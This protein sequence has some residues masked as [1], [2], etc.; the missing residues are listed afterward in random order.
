[1]PQQKLT[2]DATS[3][4]A[5]NITL[6][7]PQPQAGGVWTGTIGVPASPSAVLWGVTINNTHVATIVGASTYGPI[8]FSQG[9]IVKMTAAGVTP[10]TQYQM[11]LIGTLSP[12]GSA[13]Q[14]PAAYSN[15]IAVVTLGPTSKVKITGTVDVLVQNASIPVTGNVNA[16]IT[17]A[18]I[19]VTGN[20]NATITNAS[21]PVTG[22]VNA[23]ITNASIPVTGT[24]AI[25]SGSITATLSG[26]VS[27]NGTKIAV[28]NQPG[29]FLV[30]G[31][32]MDLLGTMTVPNG[33]V[34]FSKSFATT[35]SYSG[36]IV[37]VGA[38]AFAKRPQCFSVYDTALGTA[39][40]PI[41]VASFTT[42]G[43]PA[44]GFTLNFIGTSG[45][46]NEPTDGVTVTL[47]LAGAAGTNTHQAKIY[48][49]SNSPVSVRPDL[50]T[51]PMGTTIARATSTGA[52]TTA[53]IAAPTSPRQ[54]LL[55]SLSLACSPAAGTVKIMVGT[56]GT[57][58]RTVTGV[59]GGLLSGSAWGNTAPNEE[60]EE[61]LLL[62]RNAAL[63]MNASA[64]AYHGAIA[65]YDIVV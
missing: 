52:G 15:A 59:I 39:G 32:T 53:L 28:Y 47:Y 23:T 63:N 29:T 20:V 38:T 12:K 26:P 34:Q 13:P 56:T 46:A 1:M 49:V 50:R 9:D 40:A 61:G 27:I 54:I 7:F 43:A 48:G 44:T 24:V 45:V 4:G 31:D 33:T 35:K 8:Q 37:V 36:I 6:T 42:R 17:N 16:N 58:L 41:F 14:I 64:G 3:S 5:G 62:G 10:S 60:W 65:V 22:T 18:S 25:S 11:V 19:P 55:K 57:L 51:L 2:A 21:I 30:T